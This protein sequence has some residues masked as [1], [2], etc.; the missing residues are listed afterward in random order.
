MVELSIVVPVY[1]CRES[2]EPLYLRIAA[3]LKDTASDWELLLVNDGS[4]DNAWPV[5]GEL[6]ER[7]SRVIGLDLS[8]NFGQHSAINA[9]LEHASGE[10]VIVMDCDLQDRPEEIPHLLEA[11]RAGNE[12]VLARRKNRKDGFVKKLTSRAFHKVLRFLTGQEYDSSV[13]NFGCYDRKVIDAVLS[14]GDVSRSFPLFVRWVGFSQTYVD[15]Q[16]AQREYGQSTYTFRKAMKLAVGA[17]MTFSDRP[18]RMVVTLG[19]WISLVAGVVAFGYFLGALR[20]AFDVEGWATVVISIWLLAGLIIMI[21]G[22]IGLYVAKIFDQTKRRPLFIV[23][24]V[25]RNSNAL[26]EERH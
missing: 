9:G 18:L 10:R 14:M 4:A 5:I 7:D 23:R 22:V 12:V 24:Q 2:L 13:A 3:A 20:G 21:Q 8:R 15:V 25:A 19:L 16:H 17:M 6:V 1:G 26:P 11:S